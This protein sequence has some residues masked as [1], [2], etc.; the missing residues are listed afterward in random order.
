MRSLLSRTSTYVLV[1]ALTTLL[2]VWGAF[3][4][5][6]RVGSVPVPLAHLLALATAPLCLAGGRVLGNRF[7]AAVPGLLWLAV[8]ALLSGR[9]R[10]G[11]L[12]VT[13]GLSG[14]AFL[15]LGVLG[16]AVAVGAWRPARRAPASPSVPSSSH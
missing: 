10:E 11:D 14:L 8:A 12:V 5:P 7:G 13:G 1:L 6:L 15:V 9:R 2:A 4:V 16:A 3:F